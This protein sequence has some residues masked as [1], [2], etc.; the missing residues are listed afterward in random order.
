MSSLRDFLIAPRPAA[1]VEPV[2]PQ[3]TPRLWR[4]RGRRAAT[5]AYAPA[6]GLL[7]PPRDLP[8]AA[9]AAGLALARGASAAV[10][11]LRIAAV[12]P[13][14]RAPARAAAARLATSLR[15]RDLHAEVRG[16]LAMVV[17]PDEPG[18]CASAAARAF[19]A[20][21]AAP[22]VLAVA[23]RDDDVDVLLAARD[24]ILLALPPSTDG[25]LAALALAGASDLARA[26]VAVELALDPVARALALAGLRAPRAVRDAVGGVVG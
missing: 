23:A 17:L 15:A 20:A 22:T 13:G 3:R 2:G 7:A 24:A 1:A 16:R 25:T 14:P 21:G 4:P 10:V 9:A 26:A 19:A 11:C 6:L 5:E 12:P 18:A 8:A